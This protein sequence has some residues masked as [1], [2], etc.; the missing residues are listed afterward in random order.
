MAKKTFTLNT[1]P[2]IAEIGDVQLAFQP[3]VMG[4]EFLDAYEAL[5]EAQS[6]LGVDMDDL[7]AVESS[8]LRQVSAALKTFLARLM[9]PGSA[10][11]FTEMRLPDRVLIELMEWS[12]EL[13]GSGG[14]RPTGRSSGSAQASPRTGTP[15][16]AP[17]RS[18]ALTSTSGH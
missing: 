5:R 8:Q 7:S 2:H 11:M 17:S 3:E 14:N 12:V 10:E 16:R 1:E 18:K 15:G 9:L 4:D 13:Y 6:A